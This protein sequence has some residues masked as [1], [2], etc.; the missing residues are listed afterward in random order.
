MND[1]ITHTNDD[2]ILKQLPDFLLEM[3]KQ[4]NVEDV[5]STSCPIWLVCYDKEH[6]VPEGYGEYRQWIDSE[7]D[8]HV[9]CSGYDTKLFE[10]YIKEN[11]QSFIGKFVEMHKEW[12]DVGEGLSDGDY[13]DQ[14]F[15]GDLFDAEDLPDGIEIFD[16]KKEREVVKACLTQNDADWFIKR[17]QHDYP[18]LY[19]YVDS[20]V[21]CPQMIE[22]REWIKSLTTV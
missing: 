20:M 7:N 17:K 14:N 16:M 15:C 5:R 22:L 9:I 11:H 10:A 8:Y 21:F 2:I 6:A 12:Y 4:M 18:K 13:F 1:T 3:S 19:T